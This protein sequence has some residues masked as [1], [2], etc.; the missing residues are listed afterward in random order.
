[1]AVD[2]V[3][4]EGHFCADIHLNIDPMTIDRFASVF[5]PYGR[6]WRRAL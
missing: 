6:L 1:M 4:L 5:P 3:G 2:G